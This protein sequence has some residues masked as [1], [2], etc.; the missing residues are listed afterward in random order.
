MSEH[1][2]ELAE[3]RRAVVEGGFVF[4][5]E[6]GEITWDSSNL[7]ALDMAIEDKAI[8]CAVVFDE[9]RKLA[10]AKRA[11]A[12]ALTDQARALEAQAD[13]LEDYTISNLEKCGGVVDTPDGRFSITHSTRLEII[14]EDMVPDDYMRTQVKRTPDK[15]KA[16]CAIKAGEY[17]PGFALI[18]HKHLRVR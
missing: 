11:R 17:V 13:R 18:Q 15:V 8:A 7:D 4:N 6:T 14:D 16:T 1:L 2:Y 10:E 3:S 12:K 9:K 5:E